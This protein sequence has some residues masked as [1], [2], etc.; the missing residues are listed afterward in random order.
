MDNNEIT[1]M[2]LPEVNLAAIDDGPHY[3]ETNLSGS[4]NRKGP[5]PKF[6]MA[7]AAVVVVIVLIV[8]TT[9][10]GND[11]GSNGSKK[12]KNQAPKATEPPLEIDPN[13]K[14]YVKDADGNDVTTEV[15]DPYHKLVNCTGRH[16]CEEYEA[17]YCAHVYCD[18]NNACL[19]A[20]FGNLTGDIRCKA[21]FSC[22]QTEF[23]AIEGSLDANAM[24]IGSG[25][26][27]VAIM[28]NM[29]NI[30]CN[31][32]QSCRKSRIHARMVQCDKG[33]PAYN[34]CDASATFLVS[35]CLMCGEEY[36]CG[37]AYNQ[38]RYRMA[39]E[40]IDETYWSIDAEWER[41]SWT[42]CIPDNID[43]TCLDEWLTI[44]EDE[45]MVDATGNTDSEEEGGRLL[46][47]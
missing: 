37:H 17:N 2:A 26:C 32:P 9:G 39:D 34:A 12:M 35:D 6:L 44:F 19:N 30:V 3:G 42:K 25:A 11:G 47:L 45:N 28:T 24:C 5:S 33:S 22:H 21:Q 16:A 18:G 41:D 38:C 10:G 46:R 27:D 20:K 8:T 14:C 7:V 31:G 40:N 23:H 36:G 13:D 15:Y 29:Q 4:R 43:G 1:S